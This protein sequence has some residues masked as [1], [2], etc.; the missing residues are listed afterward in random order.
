MDMEDQL[1]LMERIWAGLLSQAQEKEP[2]LTEQQMEEI[3]RR[4]AEDDAAPDDVAS[5]EEVKEE[6]LRRAG[7]RV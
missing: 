4:L 1:R 2:G 7:R 6:A 5:W 3:D